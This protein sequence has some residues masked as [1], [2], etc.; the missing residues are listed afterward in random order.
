[1][2]R[3]ARGRP[4]GSR[5]ARAW[6]RGRRPPPGGGG[7]GGAIPPP[8]PRA[9]PP[10]GSPPPRGPAPGGGRPLRGP[11]AP[12]PRLD[13][14]YRVAAR[15]TVSLGVTY[16]GKRVDQDFASFPFPRVELP[17]YTRVDLAGELEVI[18]AGG[19]GRERGAGVAL[20]ARLEN[21]FDRRYEEARHFPARGR[22]ILVGAQVEL[23]P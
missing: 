22:T 17:D 16:V 14:R 5:T 2:S 7:A 20:S 15:G 23:G 1:M 19:R 12:P 18:P 9:G 3:T 6:E 4:I 13:A 8:P 11:P 10:R 21:L